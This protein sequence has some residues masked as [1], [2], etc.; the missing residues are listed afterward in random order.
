[1]NSLDSPASFRTY[2]EKEIDDVNMAMSR[3]SM[4]IER[5]SNSAQSQ[6]ILENPAFKNDFA[7][8]LKDVDELA[9]NLK[10]YNQ[11][12]SLPKAQGN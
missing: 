3:L 5:A 9:N 2:F 4:L 7:Q 1:M 10:L 12:L 11:Q 8:L 6:N